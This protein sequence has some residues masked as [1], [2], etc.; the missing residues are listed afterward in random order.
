MLLAVPLIILAFDYLGILYR[1]LAPEK[2]IAERNQYSFIHHYFRD[3]FSAIFDIQL[4][5]MLPHIEIND[6]TD[7]SSDTKEH[8]YH[9]FLN[10][11][12]WNQSKRELIS[13]VLMEHRNKP[14][15]N[16]ATMNWQLP[17][18]ETDEQKILTHAVNFCKTLKAI[19]PTHQQMKKLQH[20]FLKTL[21]TLSF[22]ADVFAL[23]FPAT[24]DRITRCAGVTISYMRMLSKTLRIS[25]R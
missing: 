16:P 11:F 9:Y 7:N 23:P 24:W 18:A 19:C 3:Y 14:V 2:E 22:Q 12:Y 5:R 15:L 10:S 20:C 25:C 13:Q 6:F 4:L 1:Y 8:T 21:H 17:K